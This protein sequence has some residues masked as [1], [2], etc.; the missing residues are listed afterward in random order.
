MRCTRTL[1]PIMI[2]VFSTSFP[3]SSL[4]NSESL[5]RGVELEIRV[6]RLYLEHISEVLTRVSATLYRSQLGKLSE[7][8]EGRSHFYSPQNQKVAPLPVITSYPKGGVAQAE[9]IVLSHKG[10][11]HHKG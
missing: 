10:L 7:Q 1:L 9:Q 6:Q 2:Q 5:S 8:E 4:A 3:R 11:I